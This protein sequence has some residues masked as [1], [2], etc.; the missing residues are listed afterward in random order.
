MPSAIFDMAGFSMAISFLK[1]ML[2]TPRWQPRRKFSPCGSRC[3]ASIDAFSLECHPLPAG[4]QRFGEFNKAL[5]ERAPGA[6]LGHPLGYPSGAERPAGT[7][8]RTIIS[9]ARSDA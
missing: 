1:I 6:E 4:S 2:A 9:P 3:L 8:L 5:A 7:A